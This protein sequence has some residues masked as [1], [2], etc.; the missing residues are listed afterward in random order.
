MIG[1]AFSNVWMQGTKKPTFILKLENKFL[2]EK[3]SDSSVHTS[4]ARFFALGASSFLFVTGFLF[5]FFTGPGFP[6]SE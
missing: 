1:K 5:V 2:G 4:A 3:G 6:F